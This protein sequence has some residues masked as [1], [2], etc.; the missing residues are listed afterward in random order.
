MTLRFANAKFS[1]SLSSGELIQLNRPTS[2]LGT[3]FQ[4]NPTASGWLWAVGSPTPRLLLT[5]QQARRIVQEGK[6]TIPLERQLL[7]HIYD[8][9]L[10]EDLVEFELAQ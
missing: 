9:L 6:A 8:A 10:A 1:F 4:K 3:L 7:G 2:M 5:L